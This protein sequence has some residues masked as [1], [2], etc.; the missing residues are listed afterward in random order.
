MGGAAWARACEHAPALEGVDRNRWAVDEA[1]WTWREF[2]LHGSARTGD[3]VR[4]YP[5]AR[6]A[7]SAVLLAYAVNELPA[8]DAARSFPGSRPPCAPGLRLLIVEAIALRDKSWWPE[9]AATP[10]GSRRARR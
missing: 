10:G 1:N 8:D 4:H 5:A 6:T 3:V 7:R 2:G 9:W